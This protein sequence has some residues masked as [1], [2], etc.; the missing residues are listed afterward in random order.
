[1]TV[2]GAPDA[3]T[4]TEYLTAGSGES[5]WAD[6]DVRQA[7]DAEQS[8]QLARLRLP[9]DADG[10]QT[11]PPA[12]VESLC[13]RVAHNLAARAFPLGVQA[14]VT[15]VAAIN[16]YVPGSDAEVRRLEAPY[17]RRGMVF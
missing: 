13:R 7:L 16:T 4:V 15:D 14:T 6:G 1:M 17:R 12:L 9:V 5:S 11:Y 3:A 8:D 2:I 10:N